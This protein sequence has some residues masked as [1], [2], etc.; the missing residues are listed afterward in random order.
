VQANVEFIFTFGNHKDRKLRE[1]LLESP[2]YIH[3][4]ACKMPWFKDMLKRN[5]PQIFSML[6]QSE[7]ALRNEE[8]AWAWKGGKFPTYD[9]VFLKVYKSN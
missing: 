7:T 8:E 9:E 1:V 3:W 4:C 5:E 6:K 2:S